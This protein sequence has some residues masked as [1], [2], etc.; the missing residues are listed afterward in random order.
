MMRSWHSNWVCGP[1]SFFGGP[2]GWFIDLLFWLAVILLAVWLVR[3]LISQRG[4]GH[5]SRPSPLEILKHR[6]AA[7]EIGSEEFERMKRE[8][9]STEPH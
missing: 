2:W 1:G 3:S 5:S 4:K 7:G 6:Y 9:L 8:I